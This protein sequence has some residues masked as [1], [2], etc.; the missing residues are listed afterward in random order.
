MGDSDKTTP[1]NNMQQSDKKLPYKPGFEKIYGN[2]NDIVN[3]EEKTFQDGF[4]QQ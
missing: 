1:F 2:L 3:Y 4:Y